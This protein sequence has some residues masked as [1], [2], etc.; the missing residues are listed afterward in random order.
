M[1][2]QPRLI[3]QYFSDLH[4]ERCTR[5]PRIVQTADHLILAGDIGHPQT[6]IYQE[7]IRQ[8]SAR[9]ARV[10][11]V[12]GNHEWDRGDPTPFRKQLPA[13]VHLLENETY[14]F[15]DHPVTIAGCTLWTPYTRRETNLQSVRFLER[16]LVHRDP[17]RKV[18]CVTHHLPS[19][20]L[21]AAQYRRL[22][23]RV[24]RRFAN[25]LDTLMLF[26]W[27]PAFWVCGHSHS[28]VEKRIGQ[29]HCR[30]NT[31][32]PRYESSIVVPLR[33]TE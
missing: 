6:D 23:P 1:R 3:F 28:I 15:D 27:A 17:E 19:F 18:I 16:E 7:F 14:A 13:N 8:C 20:H 5:L 21:I 33:A 9:Y 22:P 25:S 30:I 31:Y 24:Q 11:M 29:T 10:F 12:Y 4:L 32:A 26:S 2:I